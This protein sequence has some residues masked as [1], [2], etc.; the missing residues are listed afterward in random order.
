MSI[1]STAVEGLVDH[2]LRHPIF[3][4]LS[5]GV[6]RKVIYTSRLVNIPKGWKYTGG[7]KQSKTCTKMYLILGGSVNYEFGKAGTV[8]ENKSLSLRNFLNG[9]KVFQ[10]MDR[11]TIN[12]TA[13]I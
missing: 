5:R 1:N 13:V 4:Q 8:E 10:R 6:A 9:D 11:L 12:E 3:R 7:L 2:L